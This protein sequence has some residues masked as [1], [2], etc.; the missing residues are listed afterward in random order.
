MEQLALKR[1]DSTLGKKVLVRG[2]HKNSLPNQGGGQVH[3]CDFL[4]DKALAKAIQN[5]EL[6][7]CRS[8]Y[9]TL[10]D[11][12]AM[13]AQAITTPTPQQPEQ[14][15]LAERCDMMGWFQKESADGMDSSFV[16]KALPDN[17][18]SLLAGTLKQ[19]LHKIKA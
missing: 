12:I 10:C 11:L 9:S 7:Y 5:A 3:V 14:I 2:T 16:Q 13:G 1:F 8:G 4:D 6:V 19:F 18:A 15:Y 17:D